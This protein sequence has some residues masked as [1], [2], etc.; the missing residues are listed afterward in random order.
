[1]VSDSE[2]IGIVVVAAGSGSRYGASVP[3][4]FLD[5]CGRPV[6]RHCLDTFRSALPGATI[7]LVLSESGRGIWNDYCLTS[8][9][10]SPRMAPGGA[11]RGESVQNGL[12]ALGLPADAPVLVHDGARP[13]L[14]EKL[15]ADLL[16]PLA[17]PEVCGTVPALEMSDSMVEIGDD[18]GGGFMPVARS[19]YRSVQ[20]PQVFRLGPLT[21]AFTIPDHENFTDELSLMR[22]AGF[23]GIRLVP[24]QKSNI[25][26]THPSDLEVAEV[27]MKCCR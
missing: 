10:V 7:V 5:L 8:G 15:V 20:T 17:S 16:A 22:A 3:K 18:G 1:M 12:K 2:R 24:G 4:Q 25:K 21:E 13:L 19:R 11:T 26:I 27:L 9:Y 6:L 14:S 23:S